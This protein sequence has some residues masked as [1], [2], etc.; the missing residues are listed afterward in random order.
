MPVSDVIGGAASPICRFIV[1]SSCQL[2][3]KKPRALSHVWNLSLCFSFSGRC[4]GSLLSPKA[5]WGLRVR[6]ISTASSTSRPGTIFCRCQC[7]AKCHGTA[8]FPTRTPK[9]RRPYTTRNTIPHDLLSGSVMFSR[10]VK[11]SCLDSYK[12]IVT[13]A[14][15]KKKPGGRNDFSTL[16]VA[17]PPVG[18]AGITRSC[19]MTGF[20]VLQLWI[21]WTRCWPSTLTKGLKWRRLWLIPT[22]NNIMT[23]QMR[24]DDRGCLLGW[25]MWSSTSLLE[26]TV[27]CISYWS[28]PGGFN[29]FLPHARPYQRADTLNGSSCINVSCLVSSVQPVA[30][31][32]FKFDME[33][34]DLPKETLKELIFEETARFQPGFRS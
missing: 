7:A 24:S 8:S 2:R 14:R 11:I 30:E 21:C 26:T 20:L 31:A 9:V 13:G 3:G 29:S 27:H 6:R 18:R 5:S 17:A 10:T 19:F 32:P 25:F 4:C 16:W 15:V 33:L 22:W 1:Q 28:F 34:D 23:L 12:I